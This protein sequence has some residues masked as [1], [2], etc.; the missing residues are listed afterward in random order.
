M[1]RKSLWT[2]EMYDRLAALYPHHTNQEL[3]A[4]TGWKRNELSY[5]AG[6]LGI[7]KTKETGKRALTRVTFIE[8]HQA[9]IRDNFDKYTNSELAEIMGFSLQFIRAKCHSM[10]L[11]RMTLEYWTEEQIQFLKDNFQQIGDKELAEIFN[12]KWHKNKSWTFKHIEK[13]RM[14]LKLKR[15][16]EELSAIHDRNVEMGRF[17]NCPVGRWLKHGVFKEGDIRMWRCQNGRYVPFIK[18]NNKFIHWAK[19]TWEKVHGPVAPGMNVVFKNNNP[20]DYE[21]GIEILEVVDNAGLSRRNSL[22]SSKGLSDN[23][24]AGVLTNG[25]KE[26]RPLVRQMPELLE[27]K[28]QELILARKIKNTQ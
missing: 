16:K 23:Y 18:V 20:Y 10:G 13:K 21:R 3:T 2:K 5:R 1:G 17:T 7:V 28:R 15:S 26:I 11:Y 9:F 12:V 19:Y 14:Y 4:I 6:I 22:I 24:I 27:I 8:D 25:K